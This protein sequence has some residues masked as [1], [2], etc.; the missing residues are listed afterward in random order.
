M[1][2]NRA[3]L[4]SDLADPDDP[5]TVSQIHKWARRGVIPARYHARIMRAAFRR[6][7]GLTADAIVQAHDLP[8]LPKEDAA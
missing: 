5:V 3:A 6:G 4:A 7:L 8:M 1:W 2:P